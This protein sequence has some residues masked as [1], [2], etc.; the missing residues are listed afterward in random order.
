MVHPGRG[1]SVGR[2]VN[3]DRCPLQSL[4]MVGIMV[5]QCVVCGRS[6]VAKCGPKSRYDI[7]ITREGATEQTFRDFLFFFLFGK[8]WQKIPSSRCFIYVDL[9]NPIPV[10]NPK[11]SQGC[12][13]P[14]L[15]GSN[16]LRFHPL[17]EGNWPRY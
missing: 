5:A 12:A 13:S 4:R 8:K 11:R 2:S 1:R 10:G 17:F 14:T 3:R 6:R 15:F 16:F 7:C 9:F